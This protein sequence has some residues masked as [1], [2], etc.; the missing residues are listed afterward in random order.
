MQHLAIL[1]VLLVH[2]IKY[3]HKLIIYEVLMDKV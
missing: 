2:N 1:T 3:V